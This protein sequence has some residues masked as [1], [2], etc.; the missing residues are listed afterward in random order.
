MH[1]GYSTTIDFVHSYK[2]SLCLFW[3]AGQA[4][5]DISTPNLSSE[6]QEFII[7]FDPSCTV[8]TLALGSVVHRFGF[9]TKHLNGG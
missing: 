7:T 5:Q 1:I 4:K 3:T 6:K 9:Q 2:P 8:D